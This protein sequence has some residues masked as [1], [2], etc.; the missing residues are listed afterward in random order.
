MSWNYRVATKAFSYKKQFE[1]KNEKLAAYPD[2][3]F[4]SIVD[5][6]YDSKEDAKNNLASS[7][8][9]QNPLSNLESVEDLKMMHKLIRRAFKLPII[10]LD[11]FPNEWKK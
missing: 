4:F 7:Y 1:G 6:Y 8:V 2:E 3:R 11:N 10:D 9:E 5:A